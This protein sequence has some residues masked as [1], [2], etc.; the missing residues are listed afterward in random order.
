MYVA[1]VTP[2][3]KG[4]FEL[5]EQQMRRFVDMFMQPKY[6]EA[7][8]ALIVNP[9]AG[10]LYCLNQ[11]EKRRN[12]EVVVDEVRGR[13]PVLAGILDTTTVGMVRVARDAKEA[14]VDGFFVMPPIGSI[15]ITI[16]WNASKY[17]EV[18]IDMLKEISSVD[19]ELPLVV[20]PTAAL[21]LAYGEGIPAEPTIEICRALPNI[22]GW[23][24]TY[25]YEG[26]KTISR[27]L[28]SLDPS[29]AIFAAPGNFFHENLLN[30]CFDG[31]VSGSFCYALEPMIDHILAWRQGNLPE[32]RRI[33]EQGLGE[34]HDYVYSDWSRL[35]V[36]YKI[37]AWLRG[38]IDSPYMRPPMPKP[39]RQEVETLRSL[40]L[41][42]E[43]S[44][45]DQEAIEKV[46][47]S[48][49]K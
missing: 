28:R 12:V 7:G 9:E 48:L 27:T 20:H 46:T 4:S 23:K 39:Q 2:F 31:T 41:K 26:Y 45:I 11:E 17:P 30:N 18:F 37:G 40:L 25:N 29:V 10:E 35:H 32:A 34:L 24:M 16:G 14:G 8:I 33:W 6:V 1:L 42:T 3:H 15:D 36:R 47:A 19:T 5:D 49:S 38:F 22:V 44:I 43:V 21:S 13:A